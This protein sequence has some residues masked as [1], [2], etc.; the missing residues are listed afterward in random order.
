VIT[1]WSYQTTLFGASGGLK[2]KVA[3]PTSASQFHFVGESSAVVSGLTTNRLITTRIPVTAGDVIGLR[4]DS[5]GGPPCDRAAPSPMSVV[6]IIPG[7]PAVGSTVTQ[8]GT[9][10]SFELDLS[11]R[12]EPDA[13]GDLYGDETQDQCPADPSTHGPCPVAPGTTPPGTKPSSTTPPE[14]TISKGPK[15]KP[16]SKAA[17]FDFASS[18]AGSTFECSL[19]GSPFRP[20]SSPD[21]VKVRKPG[22]HEFQVRARD[23]AGALDQ[24]P[25]AY[26]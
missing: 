17:T 19:D 7:D 14:T 2:L 21:S 18:E 13:D 24:S 11:A 20:C 15:K 12:L 4:G 25:A 23:A 16:T 10:A 26:S 6:A 3:S 9:F 8:T 22:K 5:P 1:S